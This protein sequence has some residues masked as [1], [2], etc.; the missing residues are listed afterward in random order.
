MTEISDMLN[1]EL[2][3]IIGDKKLK[4]KKLTLEEIFAE[5]EKEIRQKAIADAQELARELTGREKVD[6]LKEVWKD[7]PKGEA[8]LAEVNALMGSIGGI[9][10]LLWMSARKLQPDL[11]LKDVSG[12]VGNEKAVE[13]LA[14]VVDFI[15][16]FPKVKESSEGENSVG[17][18]EAKLP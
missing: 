1:T 8:L 13:D 5:F 18:P 17:K 9:Q 4:V 15:C 10:K 12:I 2:E 3:V 7:L 16:G 6:F 11:T 14:P